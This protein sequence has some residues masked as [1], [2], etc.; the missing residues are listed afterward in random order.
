MLFWHSMKMC[1]HGQ[2]LLI[3]SAWN[4]LDFLYPRIYFNI[5]LPLKIFFYH[6]F[7][8]FFSSIFSVLSP[9]TL[10]IPDFATFERSILRKF[11]LILCLCGLFFCCVMGDY[12]NY[13]FQLSTYILTSRLLHLFCFKISP[14]IFL[15]SKNSFLSWEGGK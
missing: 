5:Y 6:F 13:I 7:E 8:R 1:L 9:N 11:Y 10:I 15:G 12:I 3:P 2:S 14:V 4:L